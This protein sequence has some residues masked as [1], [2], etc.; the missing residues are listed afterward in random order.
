MVQWVRTSEEH[1]LGWLIKTQNVP[2]PIM[3][4]EDSY[5][6]DKTNTVVSCIAISSTGESRMLNCNTVNHDS[7]IFTDGC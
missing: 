1:L 7:L 5:Q 4:R 6:Y 3:A 2:E